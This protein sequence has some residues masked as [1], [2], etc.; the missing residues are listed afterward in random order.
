MCTVWL[1]VST[2]LSD[3]KPIFGRTITGSPLG[4]RGGGA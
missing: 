2:W 1:T 4:P 3:V